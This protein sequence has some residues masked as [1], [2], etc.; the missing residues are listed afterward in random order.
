MSHL[1]AC[2]RKHFYNCSFSR[3]CIVDTLIS[4]LFQIMQH[5]LKNEFQ[6]KSPTG[7]SESVMYRSLCG[8]YE[9]LP[10][11]KSCD[12][13]CVSHLLYFLY[14]CDDV[15]HFV[16]EFLP[17]IITVLMLC[18][19]FNSCYRHKKTFGKDNVQTNFIY[20]HLYHDL[21]YILTYLNSTF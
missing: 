10:S 6:N 5:Y 3:G 8:V 11:G 16:V 18:F 20:T 2:L 12:M 7:L 14:F 21:L 1:N 17:L 13:R 9:L 15:K 19:L 4:A